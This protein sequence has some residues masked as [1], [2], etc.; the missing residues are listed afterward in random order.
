MNY[1]HLYLLLAIFFLSANTQAQE[2]KPFS[3]KGKCGYKNANGEIV[4]PAEY[5]DCRECRFF[6]LI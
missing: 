2:L 1:T 6:L 3:S 5:D 4:V